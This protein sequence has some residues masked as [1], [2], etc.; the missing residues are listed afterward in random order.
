MCVRVHVCTC[1]CVRARKRG[2]VRVRLCV[3][4]LVGKRELVVEL[5]RLG[6]V[7]ADAAADI[8]RL[9]TA[10]AGQASRT[11]GKSCTNRLT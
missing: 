5:A 2:R 6:V 10:S 1:V 3:L 9:I 4:L 7:D 8:N 11:S